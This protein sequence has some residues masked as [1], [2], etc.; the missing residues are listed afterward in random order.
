M[1]RPAATLAYVPPAAL[2]LR[3]LLHTVRE[4]GG[5]VE[6]IL[7]RA[8]I[9]GYDVDGEETNPPLGDEQFVALFGECLSVLERCEARRVGRHAM[10]PAEFRMMC[11]CMISSAS[12]GQAIERAIDFHRLFEGQADALSLH[13]DRSSA[14]F[15]LRTAYVLRDA[16]MIFGVLMGLSSF[17]RLFGWLVGKELEPLQVRVS[18]DQGALDQHLVSWLLPWG[19]EYGAEDN[20]L[21]FP[22][23]YL[24]LPVVRGAAELDKL[25]HGFPFDLGA[26]RMGAAPP[27]AWVRKIF[28]IALVQ[29]SRVPDTLQIARQLGL[30]PATLKRRLNEEGTSVR[31]LKE[32]CRHELALDLLQNRS[33]TLAEI[34]SRLGFSDTTTFSRAFKSWTGRVPSTMRRSVHRLQS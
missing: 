33:L 23:R 25:L 6:G 18:Y 21:G 32:S 5:D 20:T 31:Q 16:H 9:P 15:C 8:G 14:V 2:L 28:A 4:V 13:I 30:S 12:L 24:A 26:G 19:V 1:E 34:A 22:A 29:Q 27:S 17:V 7:R 3:S 11:Y 10:G